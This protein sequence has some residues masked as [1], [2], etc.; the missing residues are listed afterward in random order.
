M[1]RD[2]TPG[3]NNTRRLRPSGKA[4]QGGQHQNL[5]PDAWQQWPWPGEAGPPVS[6]WS[7]SLLYLQEYELS[8]LSARTETA[9]TQAVNFV[10]KLLRNKNVHMNT[11]IL[12]FQEL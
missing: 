4:G 2:D 3:S 5:S 12:H 6:V 8:V 11:A 1:S 7:P 10:S 9:G